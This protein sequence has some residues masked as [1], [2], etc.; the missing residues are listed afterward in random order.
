MHI[1]GTRS[2]LVQQVYEGVLLGTRPETVP[3]RVDLIGVNVGPDLTSIGT[4]SI[5]GEVDSVSIPM[6][7]AQCSFQFNQS[8]PTLQQQAYASM[9]GSAELESASLVVP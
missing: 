5:T 8:G 2:I 1:K 4:F 3:V 9:V 6:G 7:T